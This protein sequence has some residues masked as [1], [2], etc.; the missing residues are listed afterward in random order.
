MKNKELTKKII[1][2]ALTGSVSL[3][4]AGCNMEIVDTKYGQD[5]ALMVGDDTA[6]TFNI[7]GWKDY[8]GE[9]Y[10]ISTSDGLVFLTSSFDT[11]LF[12]NNGETYTVDKLANNAVSSNGEVHKLSND[13]HHVF[14]YDFIDLHWKYNKVALFNKN[15]ALMLNINNWRDYEGEQLQIVTNEGME[16]LLS[17]YNSKLFYDRQ[18]ETKAEDVT[19]MYVGSDGTVSTLGKEVDSEK[20]I[21]YDIIDFNY[22]FNKVIIFKDNKAVILPIQQWKDYEGEQLQIKV[23][24]GPIIVTAAYDSILIDDRRSNYKAYDVA[25]T[26]ADEVVDLTKGVLFDDGVFFNKQIIDLVYGF[27]NCVISNDNSSTSLPVSQWKDYEG[28]QLQVI[29]PN[30]DAMLTSSIFLDLI[31]DGTKELNADTLASLYS[32]DKVSQNGEELTSHV[33]FNKQIIDLE[34]HFNYAL[35]VENG[36]VTIIPLAKWKDY[37]NSKG[38]KSVDRRE[39]PDGT[40]HVVVTNEEGSPNCEQLQ[41]ELPDGTVVLTSAYDTIL[42][43][44]YDDIKDYAEM[45]RGENG[46]ITDLT[47]TFGEPVETWWNLKLIDTKWHFNYGIYNN[48]VNSQIFELAKWKDFADGEQ[49]QL[50]FKDN[51]GMVSSY[52]NTSLV[53]AEDEKKVEAIAKAFAGEELGKGLVIKYYK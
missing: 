42:I 46:V 16:L 19:K 1:T 32:T 17:S 45:F 31:N 21:N 24:N 15:K 14:N 49:V 41:L 30:G 23:E 22:S 35:H 26:I 6:I 4:A 37:Y 53:Y 34:V 13:E 28:E 47:P 36:N 50:Y 52:C 40:H 7:A 2:A 10:Q 51:S 8:E 18:S 33:K 48:G 27:G 43:R 12:F 3:T 44:T 39:N 9:Q 5:T 11:D 29:L 25:S 38:I 20:M